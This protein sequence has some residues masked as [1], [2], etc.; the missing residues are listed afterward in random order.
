MRAKI[1]LAG[2]VAIFL[3]T[4]ISSADT[5]V[6]AGAVSSG[7]KR[8]QDIPLQAGLSYYFIA[9]GSV[10]FGRWYVNG[11][12]LLHDAS[13]EFNAKG[14]ADPLPV[15]QNSLLVF[16]DTST[17]YRS[18]HVYRSQIFKV[19]APCLSPSG[20]ST[21]TTGTTTAACGST[22]DG[23]SVLRRAAFRRPPC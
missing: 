21:P 20:S 13:Y 18:D 5:L 23:R 15:L 7:G 12:S 4:G 1:I 14:Y 2:L 3:L 16:L 11:Q 8:T 9:S 17:G 10:Y 19:T 6:W 22:S